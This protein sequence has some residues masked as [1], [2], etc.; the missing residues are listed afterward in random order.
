VLFYREG[1]TATVMVIRDKLAGF[2][3]V[4][5]GG[6]EEVP[7]SYT[8]HLFFK[9]FG[10]LGR[11]FTATPRRSSFSASAAASRRDGHSA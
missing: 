5:I 2:K 9:M 8:G 4:Y 10:S 1:P 11:S 3:E 7:T 6:V